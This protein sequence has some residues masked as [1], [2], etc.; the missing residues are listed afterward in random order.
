MGLFLVIIT[1]IQWWR[2]VIREGTFL[3]FHT[4]IV[5]RGLRYGII[6]FIL[7]EVCFFFSF[8]WAFF[9]S[10]LAPTIELGCI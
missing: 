10:S 1:I 6:M 8:F 3:G 7:S 9:H 5:E 4:H 2:D